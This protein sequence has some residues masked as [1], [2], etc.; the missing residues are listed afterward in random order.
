MRPLLDNLVNQP[1]EQIVRRAIEQ[2]LRRTKSA[3]HI[4][5]QVDSGRSLSR[6]DL[7]RNRWEICLFGF[8]TL[9]H[10]KSPERCHET[11]LSPIVQTLLHHLAQ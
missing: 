8:V 5:I 7:S 1:L 2:I 3:W 6:S 4:A 11:H 10:G 9:F